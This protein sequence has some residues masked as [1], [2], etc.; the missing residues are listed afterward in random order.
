[1]ANNI[2]YTNSENYNKHLDF[3]TRIKI[4]KVITDNRDQTGSFK[5]TLKS[6]G[7]MFQKDPTTIS[8]EVK[9]HR[10]EKK[11]IVGEVTRQNNSCIHYSECKRIKLCGK[12][13]CTIHCKKCVVCKEY[14]KDYEERVCRHLKSFP[15][16]CNGCGRIKTCSLNKYFYYSDKA[17]ENYSDKKVTSR[18]G[19]NLTS[20]EFETMD[21]LIYEGLQKKQP[22]YH[23]YA[24][25]EDAMA[26]SLRTVYQYFEKNYFTA[27]N[28][29]L[30]RKV[31]YKKRYEAKQRPLIFRKNK[32]GRT[33]EDYCAFTEEH[34][35]ASIVEMDTV[36]GIKGGKALLTLHFVNF[37]FQ[38]AYLINSICSSEVTKIFNELTSVLGLELFKDLFEAILTDNGKEFSDPNSLESD[39]TTQS[40]RTKIFFTHTYSSYEKGACEKN[41]EFIRVVVPKGHSFNEHTQEMVDNMMSNINNIKRNK[42]KASPYDLFALAYGEEVTSKLKIKKIDSNS[43]NLTFPKK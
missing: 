13:S 27:K 37:N 39:P 40:Q 7:E 16:V 22:L 20:K 24:S 8:K 3:N 43:V 9:N 19:I 12:S 10:I 31:T 23:I 5:L 4:Q 42:L 29:D 15:W 26:V 38:L 36:E 18:E 41:H 35:D 33:Y 2:K 32:V 11:F 6:V 28:I 1:M 34:P 14:C 17:H 25:N 21:Q 30:P